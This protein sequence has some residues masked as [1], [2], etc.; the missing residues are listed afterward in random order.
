MAENTGYILIDGLDDEPAFN[1]AQTAALDIQA[2]VATEGDNV[3]KVLTL[4]APALE[5]VQANPESFESIG[6]SD[7]EQEIA[8]AIATLL[9][10]TAN[11]LY[12]DYDDITAAAQRQNGPHE[13]LVRIVQ[14]SEHRG[15]N[16]E[17]SKRRVALSG[18]R[19]YVN[20]WGSQLKHPSNE[21]A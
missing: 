13:Q 2:A 17:M 10:R 7:K 11:G 21:V 5:D 12:L 16:L 4:A 18:L 20:L 6:L 9:D 19:I 14:G 15:G 1:Q 8:R 3:H